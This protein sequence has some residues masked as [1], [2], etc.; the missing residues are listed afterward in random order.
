MVDKRS[1]GKCFCLVWTRLFLSGEGKQHGGNMRSDTI[2]DLFS[3]SL[4]E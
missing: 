4:S 2:G 1:F 3:F